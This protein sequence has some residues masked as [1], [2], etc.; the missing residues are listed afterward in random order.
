MSYTI[1]GG[2]LNVSEAAGTG[3]SSMKFQTPF[4]VSGDFIASVDAAR[5]TVGFGGNFVIRVDL[6]SSDFADAFLSNTDF[7]ASV[8]TTPPLTNVTV[9]DTTISANLQIKRVGSTITTLYTDGS[10]THVLQSRSDP[11]FTA[12]MPIRIFLDQEAGNT[13]AQSGYF[14]NLTITSDS[15]SAVPLPSAAYAG[16]AIIG[17]LGLTGIVRRTRCSQA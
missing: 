1:S 15:I 6:G 14:D 7:I 17:A 9:T 11:S 4:S 5:T 12:T 16:F 8:I 3:N 13:A 10:G 2:L